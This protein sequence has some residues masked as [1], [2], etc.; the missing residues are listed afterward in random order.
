MCCYLGLFSPN[1]IIYQPAH[2]QVKE[3]SLIS[4]PFPPLLAVASLASSCCHWEQGLFKWKNCSQR[5]GNEAGGWP[6]TEAKSGQDIALFTRRKSRYSTQEELAKEDFISVFTV[7]DSFFST[8]RYLVCTHTPLTFQYS[9][10]KQ[11]DE[12]SQKHGSEILRYVVLGIKVF[13]L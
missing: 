3:A 10:S 5:S 9:L 12:A 11:E 4:F 1:R 7:F 13:P 2:F 8:S 6:F